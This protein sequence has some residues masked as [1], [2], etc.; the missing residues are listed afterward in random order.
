M[1][2]GATVYVCPGLGR[3]LR[4]Y[5]VE[6]WEG[7]TQSLLETVPRGAGRY[8][9]I[10]RHAP[11][12]AVEAKIDPQHRLVIP[13]ELLDWAQL[14]PE[15]EAD[16]REVLLV[17]AADCVEIWNPACYETR[18]QTAQT[19]VEKLWDELVDQATPGQKGP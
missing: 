14:P 16:A 19:D 5:G 3:Y 2:L 8:R 4:V 13:R 1:A 9:D 10:L 18:T 6:A 15:T 7:Y 17:G 12:N 11:G